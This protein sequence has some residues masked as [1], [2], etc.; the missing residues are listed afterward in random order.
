[1][2]LKEKFWVL[3]SFLILGHCSRG[4]VFG[5]ILSHF[6]QPTLM[7]VPYHLF[8]MQESLS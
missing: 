3:S 4:G 1:M 8:D 2:F 5:E 7:Q 6:L